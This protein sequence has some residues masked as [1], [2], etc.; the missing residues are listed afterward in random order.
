MNKKRIIGLDILRIFSM[1]GIVGLHMINQGGV[2][3]NIAP[4]TIR[5]PI[6][7]AML[8]V[9]Y[10]S[11]NTFGILSG[12]LSIE[13]KKQ[14]YSRIIELLSILLFYIIIHAVIFYGF[15]LYNVRGE[16]IKTF[17]VNIFPF[18]AGRY[19]YITG[20]TLLF[21]MMPYLNKCV[22]SMTQLQYKRLIITLFI[23]LSVVSSVFIGVDFFKIDSGYSPF[24]LIYLYLVGGYIR[25]Y[26]PKKKKLGLTLV[27]CLISSFIINYLVR[28]ISFKT[29]GDAKAEGFMINY[30]S[31]L[32]VIASSCLVLMLSKIKEVKFSK[33]ILFLSSTAFSVYIMHGNMF[34]VYVIKDFLKWTNDINMILQPV[35]ILGYIAA[36]YLVASLLDQIRVLLFKAV[37]ANK[38][39][40]KISLTI[41]KRIGINEE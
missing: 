21:F 7:L 28:L 18:A 30:I 25:L 15:N 17:L 33:L 19:W 31:P 8:T 41:E 6:I 3:G 13:K 29:L 4:D 9:F 27:L 10:L 32:S 11:V 35:V 2:I 12:F 14:R 20:Y 40:D 38:I 5:Y 26:P 36:I 16:G 1:C 34:F 37:K 24:W 22:N 23:L 39:F